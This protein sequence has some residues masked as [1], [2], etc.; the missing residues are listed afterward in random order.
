MNVS[1][2][3]QLDMFMSDEES[4]IQALRKEVQAI[5]VSST[6]VRKGTY[7]KIGELNKIVIDLQERLAIIERNICKGK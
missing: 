5:G 7:A 3:Y 6:K 2:I 1:K 4:E